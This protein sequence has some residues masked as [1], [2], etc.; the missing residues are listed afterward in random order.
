M[1]FQ[2]TPTKFVSAFHG[3]EWDAPVHR[4]GTIGSTM[5][6]ARRLALA[7]AA[8]GTVVVAEEQR[9][10]RGRAGRS[11]VSP[12]GNLHATVVLQP[13]AEARSAPGLAFVVANAVADA[14]DGLAGPGT[15]LKWPNDILR[16][17]AK[18]AGILLERTDDGAV[19]AGIGMNVSHSPPGLPYP[20]TSL[21]ALGCGAE[22]GAVLAAVMAALRVEW[23]AWRDEGFALV[24][25]RWAARGPALGSR[26]VAQVGAEQVTGRF[27]GLREDGALLLDTAAGRRAVVAGDVQPCADAPEGG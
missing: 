9:A 11:W 2:R 16:G 17:G 5:E 19:L 23:Q 22:V 4:F 24:L 3:T 7:G 18:L 20:V 15:T 12:P 14:V 13:G 21:A 27:A 1:P 25:Q 10:G 6:E 26:M 8:H